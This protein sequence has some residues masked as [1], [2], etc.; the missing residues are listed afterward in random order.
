[1]DN[2]SDQLM[3]VAAAQPILDKLS[4]PVAREVFGRGSS[5]VRTTTQSPPA[6]PV[7]KTAARL[8]TWSF[9]RRGG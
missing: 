2:P 9:A 5:R 1:M 6:Q 4:S 3:T 7:S 8:R